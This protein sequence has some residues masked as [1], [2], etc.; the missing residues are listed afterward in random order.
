MGNVKKVVAITLAIVTIMSI[1]AVSAS[2]ANTS[3]TYFS[4]YINTDMF[5]PIDARR[6][7]D[8]SAIYLYVDRVTDGSLS[9]RVRAKGRMTEKDT[10]APPNLTYKNGAIVSSVVCRVDVDYSVHNLIHESGYPFAVLD[11]R[12]NEGTSSATVQGYWSPDS[13]GTYTDP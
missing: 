9:V 4:R 8:A 13:Y 12:N 2:A 1:F 7:E 6:K 5:Y 3:D 11:F 10:E